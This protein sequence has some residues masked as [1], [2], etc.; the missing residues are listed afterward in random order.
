MKK[1]KDSSS[2]TMLFIGI[3]TG[4]AIIIGIGGI[5]NYVYPDTEFNGS[6]KTFGDIKIYVQEYK[7]P[8]GIEIPEGL[9][10]E[11]AKELWM[12]KDDAQFLLITQ[13]K[14]GKVNGLF[15]C[16]NNKR[17][18]F[19][20]EPLS[21][22]G[23]WGNATY[24]SVIIKEKVVGD[25]FRDMDFDGRFD[26]KINIAEDPNKI[27]RVIWLDESWHKIDDFSIE[28]M[29]AKIGQTLYKF[30]PNTG[31]WQKDQ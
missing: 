1:L 20:M 19:W 10:P 6:P 11:C 8:E 21:S 29:E 14:D 5:L 23:M 26:F 28:K 27:S 9:L 30:D 4:I 3:I 12:T 2:I 25:I 31:C 17:P 16:K 18:V 13:D 24:S 7:D 22:T 15:L